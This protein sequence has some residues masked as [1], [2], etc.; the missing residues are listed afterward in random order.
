MTKRRPRST[1]EDQ[2]RLVHSS[3]QYEDNHGRGEAHFL[4]DGR[5]HQRPITC[6]VRGDENKSNLPCQ[7]DSHESRKE[8]RV[9]DRGRIVASDKIEHKVERREDK[10]APKTYD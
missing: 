9:R 3:L 1:D 6:G 2:V 5:N 8:S 7:S 10:E 4:E